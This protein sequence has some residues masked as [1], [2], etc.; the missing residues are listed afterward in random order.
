MLS[1][2]STFV[3][4]ATHCEAESWIKNSCYINKIQMVSNY[5]AQKH[6]DNIKN[7]KALKKVIW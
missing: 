3:S 5:F 2:P 4:F 7:S 1:S 6:C